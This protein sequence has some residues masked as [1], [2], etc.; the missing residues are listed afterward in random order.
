M[1]VE[2]YGPNRA[3][4]L[5]RRAGW[6]VADQVLS[7]LTNFGLSVVVARAVGAVGFGSFTLVFTAF[8]TALGISRA[9]SS[10][11]LM[12][13]FS[14]TRTPRWRLGTAQA[15][16]ASL[17]IGVLLGLCCIAAGAIAGGLLGRP[18]VA[19]GLAL[20]GLLLQDCW[21]YAFFAR[22]RGGSAFAND[23]VCALVLLPVLVVLFRHEQASQTWLA[24]VGW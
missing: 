10:E 11:P 17:V 7:S 14:A 23:L 1:P 24:V 9:A 15:T 3:L 4:A 18:F 21:R 12:V 20:P 22:G 6:G 16:G 2:A 8:T 5:V 13:H 19:L